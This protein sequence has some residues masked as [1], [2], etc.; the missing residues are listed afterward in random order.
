MSIAL[1]PFY[2]P[3]STLGA[4]LNESFVIFRS[5]AFILINTQFE[6]R[7]EGHLV[8]Y[9]YTTVR[10]HEISLSLYA[11]LLGSVFAA[12]PTSFK[13]KDPPENMENLYLH[14]YADAPLKE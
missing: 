12:P 14:R 6:Q 1:F 3:I 9:G 11:E 13:F 2:L 5:Y 4:R 8:V 10:G 7:I